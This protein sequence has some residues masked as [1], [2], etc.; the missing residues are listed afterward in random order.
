MNRFTFI[1]LSSVVVLVAC[2]R[3]RLVSSG[4]ISGLN[5]A[6]LSAPLSEP[7]RATK[8]QIEAMKKGADHYTSEL[9]ACPKLGLE[10]W[11]RR[12]DSLHAGMFVSQVEKIF[13]RKS[14]SGSTLWAYS[15]ILSTN[16]RQTHVW[17]IDSEF[18]VAVEEDSSGDDLWL[19]EGSPKPRL[20]R[21]ANRIT[22]RPILL[23]H[24]GIL[25]EWGGLDRKNC[26]PL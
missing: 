17:A 25:N 20:Q 13:P 15:G 11:Q 21:H 23:R 22:S 16:L 18:A 24:K 4:D 8:E 1:A 10:E 6:E 14:V 19:K 3:N 26:W 2:D 9:I 5:T 7:S 12:I